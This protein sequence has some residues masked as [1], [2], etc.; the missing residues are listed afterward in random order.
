MRT[1]E[2]AVAVTL[3]AF[4]ACGADTVCVR[5]DFGKPVGA[6]K[7]L[8]A[9]NN[10]PCRL[11]RDETLWEF[12]DA[13]IPYM[14]THDTEGKWG[15]GHFVDVPNVFPDFD[16]DEN[17][18]ANYDFAFTDAYLA[19]VV[20]A[21]TKVYY[22]LGVTIENH[23]R[24][25]RYH[26]DPPRDFAKWARICEH[27]VRHF[28]EGWANGHRWNVEY[29]EIWNEPE[30]R[31]MWSGTKEQYFELYRVTANHLK[32]CF[33]KIKVGGYGGCGFAAVDDEA[34]KRNAH[35]DKC[36]I[37]FEDFCKFVTDP[38]TKAPLDFFS[39]HLYLFEEKTPHRIVTHAKYARKTLDAAGL[40][41][42]ESHFNEWNYVGPRWSDYWSMRHARGAAMFAQGFCLMQT[43][44]IDLAMF[45]DAC[46]Q[47]G[48]CGL[49]ELV[50]KPTADTRT[51]TFFA[52][53]MWNA[54]YRL[55]TAVA[56]AADR[57][58]FGAAAAAKDGRKALILSNNS[59]RPRTV[60]LRM[61]GADG[62]PFEVFLL[63]DEHDSRKP[64]P[65]DV[66]KPF[67]LAPYM[68]ALVAT[69]GVA[70]EDAGE[71]ENKR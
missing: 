55:G 19:T 6:V 24:I 48:L 4:A 59:E 14:R 1:G 9:V 15:G 68:V 37:W 40:T 5:A 12:R 58:D 18:P 66:R 8:H 67:V 69:P 38:K 7:P 57:D 49:F 54:L 43:A 36:V 26:T 39:W 3:A 13:G 51:T 52:F 61:A 64:S 45:Y 31:A 41:K 21:G 63:D 65:V 47:R 50:A 60:D 34:K 70:S 32:A 2:F 35:A 46:P 56:C 44:P 20:A 42:T 27:I 17:A 25:K 22:R 30:N 10:A 28:N 53:R 33:P 23:W 71:Q 62:E 11:D 29:W 16:A